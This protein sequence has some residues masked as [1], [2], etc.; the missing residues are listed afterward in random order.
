M[1]ATITV[2]DAL[3][4]QALNMAGS[5]MDKAELLREALRTFIRV[6]AGQRLAALGG[7]APKMKNAPRRKPAT[8]A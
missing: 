4:E 7:R 6:R 1:R 8:S 3:Y 2:E 5:G